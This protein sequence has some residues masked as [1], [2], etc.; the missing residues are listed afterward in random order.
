MLPRLKLTPLL[1]SGLFGSQPITAD[2]PAGQTQ[3][4]TERTTCRRLANS[5]VDFAENLHQYTLQQRCAKYSAAQATVC[6][7]PTASDSGQLNSSCVVVQ[8]NQDASHARDADIL[9][10]FLAKGPTPVP[11]APPKCVPGKPTAAVMPAQHISG[12][13]G[14]ASAWTPANAQKETPML[15]SPCQAKG[16]G[17]LQMPAQPPAGTSLRFD[18]GVFC[19]ACSSTA[20]CKHQLS[21]LSTGTA[22]CTSS[23]LADAIASP[24][25]RSC[26]LAM[27]T[28]KPPGGCRTRLSHC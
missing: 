23:S 20:I 5:K 14:G 18:A 22:A 16:L 3:F 17:N 7:L 24:A 2:Q 6:R 27:M 28:G 26:E 19:F 10:M 8:Q 15:P 11:T 13:V 12:Y 9:N 21:H 1:V 25:P 4:S